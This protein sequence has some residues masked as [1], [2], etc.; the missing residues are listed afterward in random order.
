M[1]AERVYTVEKILAK[2]KRKGGWHYKV[3]W[4]GYSTPTWETIANCHSC[5]DAIKEF[6]RSRGVATTS[7]SAVKKEES[8]PD[9]EESK[10]DPKKTVDSQK[11]VGNQKT[12]GNQK[13]LDY[14]NPG[15][16]YRVEVGAKVDKILGVKMHEGYVVAI[17]LYADKTM[18]I[19]PTRAIIENQPEILAEFYESRLKPSQESAAVD[20]EL[21]KQDKEEKKAA[22]DPVESS[23]VEEDEDQSVVELSEDEDKEN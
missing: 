14:P 7:K 22:R 6:E 15:R 4:L 8:K 17:V 12:M 20:A 19:V 21:K 9:K 10:S 5:E 2:E 18:E 13:T 3:K 1:N 16:V 11:T 23:D